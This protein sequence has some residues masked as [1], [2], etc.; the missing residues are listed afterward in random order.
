MGLSA[1]VEPSAFPGLSVLSVPLVS[2]VPFGQA[3]PA[4]GIFR[5]GCER[6]GLAPCE[7]AYVG[8]RYDLDALG[9]G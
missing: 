8:D 5:V 9:D 2:V 7:V 3:K 6:L 4:S 1:S